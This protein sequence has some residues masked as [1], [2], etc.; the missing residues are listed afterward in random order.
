VRNRSEQVGTTNEMMIGI[1]IILLGVL[2]YFL[3]PGS[4]RDK[5]IAEAQES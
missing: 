4:R 3:S 5:K 2:L 1:G